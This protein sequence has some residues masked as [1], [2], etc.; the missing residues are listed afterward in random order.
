MTQAN[1]TNGQAPTPSVRKA[2]TISYGL[3]WRGRSRPLIVGEGGTTMQ[4]AGAERPENRSAA[5]NVTPRPAQGKVW[6]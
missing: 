6:S 3:R 1:A 4:S 5:A 2:G